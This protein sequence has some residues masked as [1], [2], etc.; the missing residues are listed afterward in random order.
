MIERKRTR[1]SPTEKNEIWG[2]WKAGESMHEIGRAYGR[3]HPTIR[4]LLLP[5]GGM[6]QHLVTR[7]PVEDQSDS[8][9]QINPVGN[10]H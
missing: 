2:R 1:L 10:A 6:V 7:D 5:H 4:K 9:L 8:S 3:P